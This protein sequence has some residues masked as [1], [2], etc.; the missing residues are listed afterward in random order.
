M[1]K[2]NFGDKILKI[3]GIIGIILAIVGIALLLFQI[4][5]GR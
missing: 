2:E 1:A 3:L 4:I 5:R